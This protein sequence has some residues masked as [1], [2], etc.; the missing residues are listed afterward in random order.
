MARWW[1]TRRS[2]PTTS[3]LLAEVGDYGPLPDGS[4][5]VESAV[6]MIRGL[7]GYGGPLDTMEAARR[8]VEIETDSQSP[9]YAIAH[10]SLGH[11][12]YLLGDL[13]RGD[14][15][16][17]DGLAQRC[18]AR[19]HPGAEPVAR[20]RSS[21]PSAVTS[22][23]P[24]SAPS[25][26]WTSS[27]P[28]ACAPRRRP[29]LAFAALGQ[30]QAA[31]GKIDDALETLEVGLAIRR[32]TT[33][34]GVWGPIHHLLVM[35]G[36]AAQAGRH[37]A[38]ELLGELSNLMSRYT[39]GMAAMRPRVAEVQ[40]L[41][42]DEARPSSF[43]EPLTERELDVLRLLQGDLSLN[44]IAEELYLSFNTVKTHARAV[45]RKLG[46]HSRAEAVLIARRQS[47]I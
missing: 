44:E 11:A 24:G 32:Q 29:R 2:W 30:A 31:A 26:P 18:R 5:S 3:Q 37:M 40:R 20:S 33:A 27:M 12:L 13:E 46:A 10:V 1:A 22:C 43:D 23:A 6:A 8:A 15:A 41:L 21:R 35:A 4:R 39:D 16:A 28:A 38:R 42:R 25:S 45:Y 19:G 47:L 36:V 14:H 34:Q 7:F 9:Y 17:P